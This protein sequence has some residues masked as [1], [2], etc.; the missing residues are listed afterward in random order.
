[1]PDSR[2]ELPTS[3]PQLSLP[4]GPGK[5]FITAHTL[6]RCAIFST[7]AWSR[8]S[9]RP[10]YSERTQLATTE[11]GGITVFQTAGEQLDQ[12]DADVFYELLRRVFI[13]DGNTSQ[14]H[15]VR[16]N[17]GEFLQA[18]GR[19]RGG[20]TGERLDASLNRLYEARF[21]FDVPGLYKGKSSLILSIYSRAANSVQQFD[22]D[23][24]LD[25]TL[26]RLFHKNQ[27]TLLRRCE[28]NKLSDPLAKG[29]HAYYSTHA[30]PFDLKAETLRRI[31]GRETMQ[32]SKW[33]VV[34][35]TALEAVQKETGWT[36]CTLEYLDKTRT[37]MVVVEKGVT[38]KTSSK[39]T[40]QKVVAPVINGRAE[41]QYDDI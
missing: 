10:R 40:S 25:I 37:W 16:F 9:P 28:R 13:E 12:G 34:L 31:M 21:E 26:A 14:E 1:M 29:I 38:A 23:V 41:E 18:L 36:R 7:Q 17:R 32:P 15:H 20:T 6:A 30:T 3:W 22:Y 8:L 2:I 11:T 35:R 24:L 19:A 5:N 27:W 33:R 39:A 4:Y